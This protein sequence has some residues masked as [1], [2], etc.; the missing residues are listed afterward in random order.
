MTAI[1]REG[2]CYGEHM[3]GTMS[4]HRTLQGNCATLLAVLLLVFAA[5]GAIAQ[6]LLVQGGPYPVPGILT[7]PPGANVEPAPA[8]L[9]LHGT[10]SQKNEVGGLYQALAERLA[11]AGIASLRIDFAGSGDSN[12]DHRR[13][14]LSTAVRDG[15][16]ALEYLAMHP[17]VA[18][19]RLGV[20]GFSQGGL[21]AQRLALASKR[22]SYL[23]TWSTVAVDG[24]GSFADLFEAHYA[25][26]LRQGYAPIDF[27][28]LPAPLNFDLSWFEELR[29]QRTLTE[30]RAF[31]GPVLAVAGQ[32]DRT[33][34]YHQS[35]DLV[36]RSTHPASQAVILAGADHIYNVLTSPPGVS[37]SSAAQVLDITTTWLRRQSMVAH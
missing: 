1:V 30:I 16:L 18:A 23:V 8:V 36:S 10:A 33:V 11:A 7:L 12:V 26:A 14:N 13:Y 21:I 24:I 17:A 2:V 25:T 29:E 28:W 20:V 3:R 6:A 37:P 15:E 9:L 22:V 27:P 35:I 34:D 31:S 19:D 5:R 4:R 32:A